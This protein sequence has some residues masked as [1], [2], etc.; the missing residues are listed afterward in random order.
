M[1]WDESESDRMSFEIE[2]PT[3]IKRCFI[4]KFLA[5]LRCL[6]RILIYHGY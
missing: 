4:G 2:L 3:D 5:T 6:K 1:N